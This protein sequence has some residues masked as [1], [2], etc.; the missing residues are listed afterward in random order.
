MSRTDVHAPGWVKQRDP[1]W[2][3]HFQERHNHERGPCD[4]ELSLTAR[5]WIRTRCYIAWRWRG[6]RIY[7]GCRMCTEQIGR[8]ISNRRERHD[9]KRALRQGA[10]DLD[11]GRQR[12]A[13]VTWGFSSRVKRE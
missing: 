12:E 11:H 4:L 9:A 13:W 1:L 3:D 2:R 5:D 6:R 10:W 8:R 7:C